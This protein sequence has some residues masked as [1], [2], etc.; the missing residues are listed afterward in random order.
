MA[1]GQREAPRGLVR[2]TDRDSQYASNDYQRV[3]GRYGFEGSMDRKGN[4]HDDAVAE[5][6]FATPKTELV[7]RE[8]LRTRADAGVR[9][10][11]YIELLCN[12]KRRHSTLGNRSPV[13]FEKITESVSL[14]VHRN[15]S[16]PS[17]HRRSG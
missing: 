7:P 2:H 6:F 13:E 3:L 15:G 10:F 17:T 1:F 9:L 8:L 12:P 4:C 16:S 14:G 5:S 11:E